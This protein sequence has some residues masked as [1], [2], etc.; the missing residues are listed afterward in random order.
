MVVLVDLGEDGFQGFVVAEGICSRSIVIDEIL[1]RSPFGL[2]RRSGGERN[3]KLV[4]AP[5]LSVCLCGRFSEASITNTSLSSMNGCTTRVGSAAI[6]D[7]C[8][9][10]RDVCS[11]RITGWIFMLFGKSTLIA[12]FLISCN[13]RNGP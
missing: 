6:S 13:N 1:E 11:T 3:E 8:D 7:G 4:F 9:L 12:F 2:V 5:P 10:R